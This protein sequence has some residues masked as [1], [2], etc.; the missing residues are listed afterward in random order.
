LSTPPSSSLKNIKQAQRES[1]LLR[2]IAQLFLQATQDDTRLSN[3]FVNRVKL[4]SDKSICYV[5]FYTV[6]GAEHFNEVL[7]ILK[8]YK[9]SLRKAIAIKLNSRY[10]PQ[11]VF[12]YDAQFET[13]QKIEALIDQVNA[14]E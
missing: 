5:Y 4:T 9:P 8:L 6:R 11:L 3:V 10:T 2:E 1:F 7:E 14:K 13:Q 12:A